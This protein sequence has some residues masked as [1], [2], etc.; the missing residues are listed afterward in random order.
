MPKQ[1]YKLFPNLRI[2]IDCLELVLQKPKLPSSQKITWSNY[3]SR[4]TAKL[5]IGITPDGVIS[6]VPPLWTGME[7][8]KEIVRGT[9][10][11]NIFDEGDAVMADKRFIIRDLLTFK[12][13]HL[14]SPAFCWGPHLTS[15][16]TTYSSR[17]AFLCCHVERYI[18]KLK[19]FPTVIINI[20]AFGFEH[21]FILYHLQ[22][23]KRFLIFSLFYFQYI[24]SCY[25]VFNEQEICS[26]LSGY[27]GSQRGL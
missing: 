24:F 6:I 16:L 9:G 21:S 8:D 15:R 10:L 2:V 3:K 13:V 18:V 1:F 19:Q 27:F 5:L 20:Q 4:N 23:N 14:I 26:F 12:K 22:T 17:V 25:I 7:S 11:V